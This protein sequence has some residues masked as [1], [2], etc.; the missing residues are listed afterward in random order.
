[1]ADNRPNSIDESGPQPPLSTEWLHPECPD[2]RRLAP[3]P[4]EGTLRALAARVQLDNERHRTLWGRGFSRRQVLAGAGA[5]GAATLGSQLVTSRASFA[6]DDHEG[7]LVVAFLRGGMDGLAA[8]PPADDL[9]LADA[10]PNIA[11]PS[12]ALVPLARGFGL[13]PSLNQLEKYWDNGQLTAVPA[14]S[15]PDLSRSHFQAQ[16]CLE[17]G[18]A[19]TGAAN[20]WLDRA[21]EKMGPGTTFR[22]VGQGKTLPRS[23]VGDQ[24]AVSLRSV[25]AFKLAGP[26]DLRDKTIEALRT[27]YTGWEHPM[28]ADVEAALSAVETAGFLAEDDYQPDTDYP[29]NEFAEGMIEIAR[30]IKADVGVRIACID[31]G[32]WDMHTNLGDVDGGQMQNRL[33]EIGSGLDAFAQDL[34]DKFD[35]V[36]VVLMSEFGRR[37]EQNANNGSDHGHGGVVLLMGGGLAGKTIHGDWQGLAPDVREQGDVPGLNDYRDVLGEVAAA[38]LGLSDADLAHVFP[39]Y[40]VA[41]LGVMA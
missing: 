15:T 17:R 25:D 20:G 3:N 21:L 8:L 24:P 31:V 9:H 4:A 34:G 28:A 10:R 14:V 13:H 6:A 2:V 39:D 30:L 22:A 35:N 16:D 5:V 41:P 11:V 18:G 23:L 12:G 1:M 27:L 40:R 36:T 19:D 33:D 37:V 26:D 38:R 29:D 7:T 32:G